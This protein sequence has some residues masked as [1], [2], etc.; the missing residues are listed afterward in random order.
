M[1]VLSMMILLMVLGGTVLSPASAASNVDNLVKR[2]TDAGT[3]LKWAISVEGSADGKT[4]P[5][6][7]YNAAKKALAAAK[8]EIAKLPASQQSKYL[9]GLE[10]NVETHITRTMRYIDAITAGEKIK[11]KQ[12]AL[13]ALID[14]DRIDDETKKAY[15]ELSEEIRKQGVLLDRVYGQST[16]NK[17]RDQYKQGALDVRNS[18]ADAVTVKIELD[19]AE[20]AASAEDIDNV[21]I[22]AIKADYWMNDVTQPGMKTQLEKDF[23]KFASYIPEKVELTISETKEALRKAA[24]DRNIPPELLKAI[25]LTESGELKQFNADGTPRISNDGGIGLMQVT[26]SGYDVKKLK[27]NTIYNIEIGA[28]ILLDKWDYGGDTTPTVNNNEKNIVENWYFAVTAYNGLSKIN[29]PTVDPDPYQ[30]KVWNYLRNNA[31]VNVG[32]LTDFDITHING[33]MELQ[34]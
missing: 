11:A 5:Y 3:V 12:A 19:R 25:A 28:D 26:D 23:Q 29:D 24:L 14:Q 13:Q 20:E 4:R 2:A 31:D 30:S 33:I 22:H 8:A 17:I 32:D 1:K 21:A 15:D 27:Y 6:T 9:E 18:S 16:R 34:E 10:K 7:Q